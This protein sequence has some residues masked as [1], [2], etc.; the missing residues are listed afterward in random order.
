MNGLPDSACTPGGVFNVTAKDICRKGYSKSVR[1]VSTKIKNQAFN[2]YGIRFHP[3]G[4][5]EVDHLIPLELGGSN[6]ISNLWPEAANPQP[7]FREKDR[8]ENY[9]HAQICK[10]SMSLDEAQREIVTDWL[11]V[12]Q[13]INSAH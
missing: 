4:A 9:L 13:K 6:D 3:T 7:G 12:F 11:G 5:Y 2:A 8:V 10:G 1:S